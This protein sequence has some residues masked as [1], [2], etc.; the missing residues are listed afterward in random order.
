MGSNPTLRS[1]VVW[2]CVPLPLVLGGCVWGV[3]R[4]FLGVLLVFRGSFG[5]VL[6]LVGYWFATGLLEEGFGG[7]CVGLAGFVLCGF[8]SYSPYQGS[9]L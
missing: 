3:Y 7:M 5:V 1:S 4:G 2:G 8:E 6:V 9:L